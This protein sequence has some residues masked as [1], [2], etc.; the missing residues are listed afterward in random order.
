MG[1]LFSSN[2]YSE[3]E[4]NAVVKCVAKSFIGKKD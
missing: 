2:N 3:E 4:F 1:Q